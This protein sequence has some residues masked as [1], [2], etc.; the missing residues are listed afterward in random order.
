[1]FMKDLRLFSIVQ[2]PESTYL[3]TA[4][5][6]DFQDG[7]SFPFHGGCP[8]PWLQFDAGSLRNRACT[9]FVQACQRLTTG[10]AWED[11]GRRGR[12][13][14]RQSCVATPPATRCNVQGGPVS[15]PW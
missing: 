13:P 15:D 9:S 3:S 4:I 12:G 1:M 11:P 5:V 7:T 10:D 8:L 6:L 14:G 2:L